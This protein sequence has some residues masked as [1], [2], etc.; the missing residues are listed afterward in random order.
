[1]NKIFELYHQD[2]QIVSR[3]SFCIK[4]FDSPLEKMDKSHF[5]TNYE[6]CQKPIK[7]F[8]NSK[9]FALLCNVQKLDLLFFVKDFI[10]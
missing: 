10:C 9:F 2:K 3:S 6:K 8:Q 1:M 5:L 4:Y 7:M